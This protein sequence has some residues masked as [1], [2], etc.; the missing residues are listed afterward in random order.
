MKLWQGS[1]SLAF[2]LAAYPEYPTPHNW[3]S[4]VEQRVFNLQAYVK[5]IS[6]GEGALEARV[7]GPF[8]LGPREEYAGMQKA[9]E[10]AVR[11]FAQ[12][13]RSGE[14][15]VCVLFNLPGN[16]GFFCWEGYA[17]DHFFPGSEIFGVGY[18]LR[19]TSLSV[20]ALDCLD[21]LVR[22][23]ESIQGRKKSPLG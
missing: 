2:I 14:S 9:T 21:T 3:V 18:A 12:E 11:A 17:P 20:F 5:T 6:Y 1:R 4:Q 10:A 13:A 19:D 7:C 8:E 15:F 22:F 16:G 23:D